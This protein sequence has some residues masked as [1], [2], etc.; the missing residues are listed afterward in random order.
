MTWEQVQETSDD[1]LTFA[2][3]QAEIGC[4]YNRGRDDKQGGKAEGTYRLG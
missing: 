1:Q 2:I 3:I 4:E